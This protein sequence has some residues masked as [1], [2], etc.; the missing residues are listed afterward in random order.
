MD[1]SLEGA[2][3][4][5]DTAPSTDMVYQLTIPVQGY[6]TIGPMECVVTKVFTTGSGQPQ[7]GLAFLYLDMVTRAKLI[8]FM[9]RA[10]GAQ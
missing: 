9:K 7:A 10:T 2:R 4:E 1:I 8:T 3:V 5:C 6:G